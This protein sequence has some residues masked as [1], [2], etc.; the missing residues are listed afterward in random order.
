MSVYIL[1]LAGGK[2]YVGYSRGVEKRVQE[3]FNG[4]GSEW[5]KIHKPLKVVTCL[6]GDL[7]LENAMTKKYMIKYGIDNVRGGAYSSVKLSDSVL[8]VLKQEISH[9]SDLCFRCHKRGHYVKQCPL[10]ICSRCGRSNHVASNCYAKK[11]VNGDI[12]P[13]TDDSTLMEIGD[14]F[15]DSF[16]SSSPSTDCVSSSSSL[17]EGF[18]TMISRWFNAF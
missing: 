7:E 9:L 3:H 17:I 2:Y 1:Q 11:H 16:P 18:G 12:L 4:T 14:E 13:P 8:R 6:P 5:T 15:F 10:R